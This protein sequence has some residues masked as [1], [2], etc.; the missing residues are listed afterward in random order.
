VKALH[1]RAV[2]NERLATWASL[3]SSLQDWKTLESMPASSI[4]ASLRLAIGPALVRLP[5]RVEQAKS[6]ETAEMM[7]KLKDLGNSFLGKFGLSTDH[8][9]FTPSESGQG[10]SMQFKR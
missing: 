3:S 5:P 6:K 1:R 7:G 9:Q 4:P 8:F 2:A 10:Y